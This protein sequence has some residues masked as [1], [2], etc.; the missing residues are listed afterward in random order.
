RWRRR[1]GEE[2]K[3]AVEVFGRVREKLAIPA[4]DF[5]RALERE[6]R[7]ATDDRA[8]GAEPERERRHDAEVAAASAQSPEQVVVLVL[9]RRHERTVGKYDVSGD[10]V[11][12]RQ[13]ELARQVADAA[14]EREPA[15]AG[16]PDDP[17][18]R[19]EAEGMR[20]V[21]D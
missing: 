12:D 8:H 11:V 4:E 10:H 9:A 14:A 15:D 3:E 13:S 20:R 5:G 7:R 21:V 17:E 16:G 2:G 1:Y 6:Q 19:R 18:R